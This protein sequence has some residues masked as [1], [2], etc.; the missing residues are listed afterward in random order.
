M[1]H[2]TTATP[3][4][5][6]RVFV[7]GQDDRITI[8]TAGAETDGRHD[9]TDTVQP[10]AVTTP[11][12][13]HTRY[14]ERFW[15]VSGSPT[16]W[17]GPETVTLRS[18]DYY[19]VP[20]NVAHAIRSGPDTADLL[21]CRIRRTRRPSRHPSPLR[22][23][24]APFVGSLGAVPLARLGDIAAEPTDPTPIMDD[25]I[26]LDAFDEPAIQALLDAVAPGTPSPLAITEIRHLGGEPSRQSADQGS[27]G[28]LSQPYRLILGGAVPAPQLAPALASSMGRVRAAMASRSSGRTP[29]NFGDHAASIYPPD[30][31]ARLQEIKRRRDP[32]RVIRGNRPLLPDPPE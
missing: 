18:G 8:L 22:D 28:H 7:L 27:A 2:P 10:A 15:V 24:P 17:A 16:I 23:L 32:S 3:G 4:T 5:Q 1:S 13:V 20:R 31:L 25:A 9:F 26:L 11:L 12:H 29:P 6:E 30:V 19:A 14:D 21:T